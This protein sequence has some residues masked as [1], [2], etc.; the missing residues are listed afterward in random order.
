MNAYICTKCG[1]RCYSA[2]KLEHLRDDKCPYCGEKI[3]PEPD[4][5]EEKT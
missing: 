5:K 2:A 1:K 4:T 3:I